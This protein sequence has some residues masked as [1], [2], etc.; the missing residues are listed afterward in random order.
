MCYGRLWARDC[1]QTVP[2]ELNRQ[3]I[4]SRAGPMSRPNRLNIYSAKGN[5]LSSSSSQRRWCIIIAAGCL[6]LIF[7]RILH[8]LSSSST[9]NTEI[10]EAKCR[11]K[12]AIRSGECQLFSH[13]SYYNGQTEDCQTA[14]E[15]L[16][17]IGVHHLD[18]DLVLSTA[19]ADNNDNKDGIASNN[20]N[21]IVAHPMEYKHTTS[22]GYSPCGNTPFNE[23]IHHL[24]S[25]YNDDNNNFFIS[26]EPKAAWGQTPQELADVALVDPP[27][28]MEIAYGSS[29]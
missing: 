10:H 17:R 25:V 23:M 18:L 6:I 11:L 5:H 29:P 27:S 20:D 12:Q 22:T 3:A 26:M 21:L 2:L 24:K 14:L 9:N 15:Q 28:R 13:R 4:Y 7:H 8:Q 19:T 1:Y 16:K